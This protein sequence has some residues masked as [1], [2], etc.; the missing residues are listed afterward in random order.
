MATATAPEKRNRTQTIALIVFGLVLVAT[1]GAFFVAQRLK[2]SS[3]VVKRLYLPRYI[4]PNGDHRKDRIRI[5]FFL[6]KPGDVTVSIVDGGGNEIR[7]LADDRHM[8]R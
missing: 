1:V 7:R 3:P 6:P 5:G 8:N 2:R 4:S